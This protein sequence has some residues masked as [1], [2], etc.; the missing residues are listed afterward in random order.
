MMQEHNPH[1]TL[2]RKKSK[3]KGILVFGRRSDNDRTS[4]LVNTIW[5][6][7]SI[8]P[9]W[10]FLKVTGISLTKPPFGGKSVVWGRNNLIRYNA[11]YSRLYLGKLLS[12]LN[13]KVFRHSGRAVRGSPLLNYHH[14]V[15]FPTGSW[16]GRQ[17][18]LPRFMDVYVVLHSKVMAIQGYPPWATPEKRPHFV[19]VVGNHHLK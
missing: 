3:V 9:T 19:G 5:P 1:T 16:F 13:L 7:Y 4:H 14:W 2:L 6:K 12:F 15:E 10:N 8:S 17:W 11:C 18:D